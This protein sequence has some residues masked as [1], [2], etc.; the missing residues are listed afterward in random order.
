MP[1]RVLI[2][3]IA[4]FF[5]FAMVT[6]VL[7]LFIAILIY[8]FIA[9]RK[10]R[11]ELQQWAAAHGFTFR[12]DN[13]RGMESRFPNFRELSKGENRYAYNVMA[14][15]CETRE[16]TGFDY[17]Y[18]TESTDSKGN[19]STTTHRFSAVILSSA[20]PLKPLYIRPENFFDK[21]GEFFGAGDINFESAEFSRNFFVKANDKRWAYDVIHQRTMEFLLGAPQFMLEFD[22]D[23]V[24]ASR[25]STFDPDDFD[26]A[27]KVI[28]G[29]LDR[30]PDYV[31]KQQSDC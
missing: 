30:L 24:I 28:T 29:I 20:V 1:Q 14:G 27:I 18:E 22:R 7:A 4:P 21:V 31:V 26:E 25:S 16:F 12:A 6:C 5:P 15:T 3:L 19:R 11:E 17:H 9:Q 23:A 13:D 8:G 2:S 10:R